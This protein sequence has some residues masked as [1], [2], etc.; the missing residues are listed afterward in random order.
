MANIVAFLYVVVAIFIGEWVSKRT[1]SWIPS[2]FVTAIIFLIGFWTV[3]PKD[4]TVRASFGAEFTNIAIGMLL[5]HLGTLMNVKKLLRQWKAVCIALLGVAGTMLFTL[6]VGVLCFGRNLVFSTVPTLTGGLV[7]AVMMAKG[8]AVAHLPELAAFPVVMFVV[9]EIISFPLIATCLKS[10]GKRLQAIYKDDPEKAKQVVAAETTSESRLSRFFTPSESYNT[11]AFILAKVA[12]IA[13][14][15][16]WLSS[17][18]H[19]A[20]NSAVFCL[21][22]GVIFHALGFLDDDALNKA[23]VFNWLM[24]GLLAYVFSQLSNA[25]PQAIGSIILKVLALIVL[26][27]LGMFLASFVL[28]KPFGMSRPMAF[29]CALTALCGFPADYILTTDVVHNLTEDEH[30]RAFL[31]NSMLPKMLVGGFATV[32]IASIFVAELFLRF[33][34]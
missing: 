22:F 16:T 15:G 4:I 21:I 26:G 5:V 17:L 33:V 2:I 13:V 31:L 14:L 27:L 20:I 18:T 28:A 8:L 19:G 6:T 3:I 10:E 23:K 32:S 24:Y 12:L 9:H 1:K 30:E 11:S 34:H 25:T 29:A 7:A